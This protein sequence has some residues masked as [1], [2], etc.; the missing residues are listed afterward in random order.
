MVVIYGAHVGNGNIARYFLQFF[1]I[2][3]FWVVSGVKGQ[4]MTQNGKNFSVMLCI[5]KIMHHMIFI[6]ATLV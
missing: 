4:K 5:S 6:Y 1:K 2:L 3:I